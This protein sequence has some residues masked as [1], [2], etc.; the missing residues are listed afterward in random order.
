M[1]KAKKQADSPPL[2]MK[3]EG[4]RLAPVTPYDAERLDTYRKG[5]EVN[6]YITQDR[7]DKLTRKYW[8]I[9]GLVV[10]QC[11]V[12]HKT[13]TALHDA[14]KWELGYVEAW[15][16]LDGKLKAR[17]VSIT[18]MDAPEFEEFYRLAMDRLYEATGV[19]PL[20]LRKEA[21]DVGEDPAAIEAEPEENEN[22]PAPPEDAVERPT[23]EM[24]AETP[25]P[26]D[27]GVTGGDSAATN[28]APID[29]AEWLT[30]FAKAVVAATQVDSSFVAATA[31]GF[32]DSCPSEE[33]LGNARAILKS[34]Q[35]IARGEGERE[36]HLL[37]IAS[38]AHMSVP[39]LKGALNL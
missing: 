28:P 11:N 18:D 20:T 31:H 30:G 15:W 33:A 39:A 32:K 7:A 3:V 13:S 36:T 16:T 22:P 24:Q 2:R 8:A 12:K 1:A 38:K 5:S 10:K 14:L 9:L 37:M 27:G 35:A 23:S 4:G 25:G 19:D 6:V 29:A 21:A 26:E 17:P 34:A